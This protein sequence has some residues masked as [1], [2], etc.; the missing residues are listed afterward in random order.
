[1]DLGTVSISSRFTTH[2]AGIPSC[3]PRSTST[4]MLRMGGVMVETATDVLTA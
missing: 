2:F 1:L 4:G 3:C